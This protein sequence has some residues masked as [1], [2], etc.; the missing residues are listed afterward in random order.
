[1]AFSMFLGSLHSQLLRKL[2]EVQL[3]WNYFSIRVEFSNHQVS[4]LP[5]SLAFLWQEASL[6]HLSP[7]NNTDDW[8]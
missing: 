1:M 8:L 6:E 2:V 5:I 7:A 3:G 4:K